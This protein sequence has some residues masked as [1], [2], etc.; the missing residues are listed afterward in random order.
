MAT[1]L[2]QTTALKKISSLRRRLRI[3]QGGTSA[4][5]TFSILAY[6]I[7]IAQT[8][9]NFV[10][11]VVSESLPH[12]KLGAIRDFKNIMKWQRYWNEDSW[13]K[14]EFV[15]TFPNDTIIEFF[16]VDSGKAHGPRRDVLFLNECNNVTY[17]IYTQLETRTRKVV[18][19]DFNPTS[20]FWVHEEVMPYNKHDFLKLTYKDNE[21]LEPAIVRSIESRKHNANYWQVYGLGEVGVL[22]GQIY[23][24]T[25][26]D[27]VPDEARLV[28]RGLDWGYTNDP[29]GIVDVYEWNGGYILDEQCYQTGL[30]NPQVA[31]ML[32]GLPEPDTLVIADSSEPKSIDTVSDYG[33]PIIGADKGPDSVR[34]GIDAIQFVTVYVTKRSLNLIKEKRNYVWKKDRNG[35]ALNVPIDL[36]NHLMDAARYALT[37]IIGNPTQSFPDQS[38]GESA[39]G[40]V[41]SGLIGSSF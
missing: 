41:F 29:T 18:I 2:K 35:K 10:I 36:W 17:E 4:S 31:T 5:K 20:S 26:I 27:G 22:E 34:N 11:S 9:D 3:V 1:L 30:K 7:H 15:Y 19:L 6:L 33:V 8:N 23:N 39:S 37:D 12:L 25:E 28:R 21:A 38:E 40:T 24:W 16:S 14:G 32:L 13:S